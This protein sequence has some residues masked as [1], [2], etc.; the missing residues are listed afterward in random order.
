M[1]T[2]D[3]LT[4]DTKRGG[5]RGGTEGRMNSITPNYIMVKLEQCT[6]R[7]SKCRK[8]YLIFII[9]CLITSGPGVGA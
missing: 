7:L 2:S 3:R 5:G 6:S 8:L 4:S 9:L 1:L